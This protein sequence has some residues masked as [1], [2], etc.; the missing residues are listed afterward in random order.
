[1]VNE[2]TMTMEVEPTIEAK[3]REGQLEDVKWKEIRQLIRDNKTSDFL[4]DSQGTLWIGKQIC[5][6]N[7]KHIKEL[8]LREVHDSAYLIHLGSTKMYKD[9]KT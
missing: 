7:Q 4:E 9:L 8:I 6:P 5:V 1:M 3:I 2:A